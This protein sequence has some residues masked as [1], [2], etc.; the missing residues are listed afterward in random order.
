MI[1]F[2]LWSE[3]VRRAMITGA[4]GRDI[5]IVAT[6]SDGDPE[7]RRFLLEQ[8]GPGARERIVDPGIDVVRN[9]PPPMRVR[10]SSRRNARRR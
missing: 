9:R 2:C 6:N 4:R 1:A 8:L 10:A 5:A 3:Y 7:R